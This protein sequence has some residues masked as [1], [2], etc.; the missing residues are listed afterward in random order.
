MADISPL[1]QTSSADRSIRRSPSGFLI[2]NVE[3]PIALRSDDHHVQAGGK[4]VFERLT[5]SQASNSTRNAHLPIDASS[6]PD[7]LAHK[8]A[9]LGIDSLLQYPSD[10]GT[11]PRLNHFMVFHIYKSTSDEMDVVE[12]ANQRQQSL[13]NRA[14]YALSNNLW[15]T[16]T[17]A[18]LH[19]L[20]NAE[21]LTDDR[22]ETIIAWETYRVDLDTPNS[23]LDWLGLDE[24]TKSAAKTAVTDEAIADWKEAHPTETLLIQGAAEAYYDAYAEELNTASQTGV[25]ADDTWTKPIANQQKVNNTVQEAIVKM[26]YQTAKKSILQIDP[27]QLNIFDPNAS[28]YLLD[29]DTEVGKAVYEL[30]KQVSDTWLDRDRVNPANQEQIDS[31]NRKFNA[32]DEILVAQRRFTSAKVRSMD[33]IALYMPDDI[34]T[35]DV[36]GHSEE[37]LNA[38]AIVASAVKGEAGALSALTNTLYRNILGKFSQLAGTLIGSDLNADAIVAA[39]LR[40]VPNPRKELILNEPAMR[41]FTFSYPMFP[42]SKAEADAIADIVTMFRYHQYPKLQN[43]GG[44]FYVF[45]SEFEIEFYL[46]QET[47]RTES[48]GRKT[49]TTQAVVN[50][51]LPRIGRCALVD[52]AVRY[53]PN[54]EWSSIGGDGAPVGTVLT[55]SFTEM[56]PLNKEHIVHGY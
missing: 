13:T 20:G 45:P 42:R 30:S 54:N 18:D 19:K 7:R 33:T 47:S 11:N 40:T 12:R 43:N 44:H 36:V 21:S 38:A 10:L 24:A 17:P 49:S 48:D 37:T 6:A 29:M 25:P 55:L 14:G 56:Q 15:N 50:G 3:T 41:R 27:T 46:L 4:A 16:I 8:N 53:V 5:D 52:V 35:N 28:A 32:D 9:I 2:D 51:Y 39:T 22:I 31:R 1:F 26:L 34:S 23:G